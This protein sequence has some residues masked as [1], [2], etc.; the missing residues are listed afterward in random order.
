MNDE[1]IDYAEFINDAMLQNKDI[2][3]LFDQIDHLAGNLRNY[4]QEP[5]AKIMNV[6]GLKNENT[7]DYK[8]SEEM[9]YHVERREVPDNFHV[10]VH[11]Y[12][13][14]NSCIKIQAG[15]AGNNDD[16]SFIIS[17]ENNY[18]ICSDPKYMEFVTKKL[19][20]I[21]KYVDWDRP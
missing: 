4:S 13:A 20:E 2:E 18:Y 1:K 9:I 19:E 14:N 11:A 17:K 16:K 3:K 6:V 10:H 5:K 12:D 8:G 15:A 21:N 7:P